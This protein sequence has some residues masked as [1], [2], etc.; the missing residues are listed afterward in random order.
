[1]VNN[2]SSEARLLSSKAWFF[3]LP[4]MLPW[5][6]HLL[7]LCLSFLFCKVGIIIILVV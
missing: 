5:D 1:M 6:K 4:P 3:Y 2:M 7:A